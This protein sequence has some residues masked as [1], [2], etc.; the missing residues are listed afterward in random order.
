ML[1]HDN[2]LLLEYIVP[3]YFTKFVHCYM[4]SNCKF[5][6]LNLVLIYFKKN[7]T[8]DD[9]NNYIKLIDSMQVAKKKKKTRTYIKKLRRHLYRQRLD[10]TPCVLTCVPSDPTCL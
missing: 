9:Y 7:I 5:W 10:R 6:S 4:F 8:N 1:I 3:K 2:L